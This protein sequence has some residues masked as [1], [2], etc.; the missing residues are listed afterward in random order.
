[1]VPKARGRRTAVALGAAAVT[2]VAMTALGAVLAYD[3]GAGIYGCARADV[4]FGRRL[5]QDPAVARLADHL[6]RTAEPARSCDDDDS[7]IAVDLELS[8]GL[9]RTEALRTAADIVQ[10]AGWARR[11]RTDDGRWCFE[12]QV[13]G[14]AVSAMLTY[15]SEFRADPGSD[16]GLTLRRHGRC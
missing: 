3:G 15:E 8:T 6:D 1:M 2:L 9:E 5:A 10:Q 14:R 7:S 11:D 4:D 12:K 13:A 16:L